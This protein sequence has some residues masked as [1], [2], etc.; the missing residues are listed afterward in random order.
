MK[1][2]SH[3]FQP[4][5]E[6]PFL[7]LSSRD[8]MWQPQ[9]FPQF[10]LQLLFRCGICIQFW[11]LNQALIPR[12]HLCVSQVYFFDARNQLF[13]TE[14]LFPEIIFPPMFPFYTSNMS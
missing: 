11:T 3:D 7:P 2:S 6:S 14:L 8:P 1:L 10:Q 13:P 9:P 4:V 5:I 12:F